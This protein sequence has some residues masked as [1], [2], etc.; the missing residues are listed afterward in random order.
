[1]KLAIKP[2]EQAKILQQHGRS[3]YLAR[4]FLGRRDARRAT[5]LYAFLRDIDDQIDEAPDRNTAKQRL[6]QLNQSL[7]H[8]DSSGKQNSGETL[9][10]SS[11]TLKEFFRGMHYDIGEVAIKSVEE[12]EDYCYCV[13]GTVG[14]MMC[15]ALS[16]SDKR[17]TDH[18]IDLGVAMQ[19]TNIARDVYEDAEMG[20]RYLPE[21]WVGDL[22]P[23]QILQA[24]G[25]SET[26][27][28]D[29]ILRLIKSAEQRYQRAR[30]GITLLPL[31]SRLAILAASRLYEG[32]GLQMQKQHAAD[33][34]NRSRL[35]T[36][37][38][39]QI[40]LKALAEFFICSRYWRYTREPGFGKPKKSLDMLMGK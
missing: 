39:T 2:A 16:C 40:I 4:T 1:M 11:S 22:T 36:S 28:K 24:D 3:F 10:I 34:H 5:A 7:A 15:E 20:R 23:Q 26:A 21:T 6:E 17:A 8:S 12:L 14:E 37:K 33:W 9:S 19:M 18:A 25:A 32:I 30:Q 27:I 35:V 13:A 29:S 38:K 31:R